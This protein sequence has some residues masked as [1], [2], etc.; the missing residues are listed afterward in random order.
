VLLSRERLRSVAERMLRA[1]GSDAAEAALV[2]DHL[3]EANL[4][5]HDSHGIGMLPMYV[6]GFH[7]GLLFPNRHAELREES[8]GLARFSGG[9]GHGQVIAREVT[10]WAIERARS[11]GVAVA[12]LCDVHHIGRVG[13]YGER[14]CEAGTIFIGFVSGL[15]A[16]PSVAPFRG[17]DGRMTSNPICIAVPTEDRERPFVLDFATSAVAIGKIRVAFNEKRKL[18][19]G[20]LVDSHGRPT[21]DP[22]VFWPERTGAVLPFGAH[23]GYGLAVACE[24]LA[25]ALTGNGTYG[26]GFVPT[27]GLRNGLLAIVIDPARFGGATS[28]SSMVGAFVD[29]VKASPPADPA[30][31]VLVAGDPERETRVQRLRDGVPVDAVTWREIL[32]AGRTLDLGED[33]LDA[34]ATPS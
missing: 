2:G 34:L 29:Y 21:D 13:T 7:K 23:K 9:L 11:N 33:E 3:V 15:G 22:T 26:P 17:S 20:V 24:L 5:G 25:G 19:P 1:M 12:G 6:R 10:D 30:E 18:P 27:G 4:R 32:D 14:A 31:P 16:P 28:F 8:G